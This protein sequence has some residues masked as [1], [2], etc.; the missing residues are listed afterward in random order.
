[1]ANSCAWWWPGRD[2]F[3]SK[4]ACISDE[5]TATYIAPAHGACMQPPHSRMIAWQNFFH[6]VAASTAR[7]N[8]VGK[9]PVL[10]DVR[11]ARSA[12]ETSNWFF[13]RAE[14]LSRPPGSQPEVP[15]NFGAWPLS[16]PARKLGHFRPASPASQLSSSQPVCLAGRN[17]STSKSHATAKL[18]QPAS[19]A[20]Q[21]HRDSL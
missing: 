18:A 13:C 8:R 1:M 19:R 10:C 3:W 11:H 4:I 7:G 12:N 20:V 14:N 9:W 16:I 2:W 6:D 21:I 17:H 5:P 15:W